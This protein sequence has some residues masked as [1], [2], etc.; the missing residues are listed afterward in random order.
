MTLLQAYHYLKGNCQLIHTTPVQNMNKFI[1]LNITK[2]KRSMENQT[3]LGQ[4]CVNSD[5]L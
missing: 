2:E 5:S 4:E 1:A 3:F